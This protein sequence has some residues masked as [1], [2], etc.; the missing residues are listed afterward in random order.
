MNDYT[1]E[2]MNEK[3]CASAAYRRTVQEKNWNEQSENAEAYFSQC[4]FG[5]ALLIWRR[6]NRN[7]F[8]QRHIYYNFWKE[9]RSVF[10]EVW[11]KLWKMSYLASSKN[12][13]SSGG[14][15]PKCNQSM[16]TDTSWRS[17]Q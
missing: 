4:E 7:F 1:S 15:L 17:D 14:W 11:G 16:S 3:S 8:V 13:R 6:F 9:I 12:S 2:K 5:Q 10:L